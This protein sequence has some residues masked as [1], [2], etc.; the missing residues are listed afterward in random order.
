MGSTPNN[1]K[2]SI[3]R[4]LSKV[5][6]GNRGAF[7]SSGGGIRDLGVSVTVMSNPIL[8]IRH[9]ADSW[10]AMELHQKEELGHQPQ[11]TAREAE[12]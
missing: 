3:L 6:M 5:L 8:Q 10:V 11:P 7:H 9:Q 2:T 12:A 4:L 1:T